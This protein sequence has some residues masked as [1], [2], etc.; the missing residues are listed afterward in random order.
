MTTRLTKQTLI[1]VI[2]MEVLGP[3]RRPLSC[4]TSL[5]ATY[6]ERRLCSKTNF[7]ILSAR[8]KRINLLRA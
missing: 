3:N 8:L 5:P 2:I 6:K 4:K 7:I 1:D